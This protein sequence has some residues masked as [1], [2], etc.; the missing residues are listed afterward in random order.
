MSRSSNSLKLSDVTTIPIKV[1]YTSSYNCTTISN[2][3][4][5]IYDGENGS[6]SLTGSIPI[7]TIN[8]LSTRHLY[9]SN[10]LERSTPFSASNYDNYLYSLNNT[11]SYS[12]SSY[13]NYL[14]ST[15]AIGTFDADIRNFPT[16]SNNTIRVISIPRSVYGENISKRSFLLQGSDYYIVDDG[17]GNLVDISMSSFY[18]I[19]DYDTPEF[20][21]WYVNPELDLY[22]I[23]VGNIIYSQGIVIITNT[24]YQNILPFPPKA[25]NDTSTFYQQNP[26]KTIYILNNDIAGTGTLI[27]SSVLLSGGNSN[28]F[29]VNPIDGSV[30]LN[31]NTPGTYTTY[32]TVKTQ[33][34][35][36]CYLTS[37][38]AT[39]TVNVLPPICG[40]N[41]GAAVYVGP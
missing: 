15:A 34:P 36:G 26:Q 14:Q 22:G 4:I 11:G 7:E 31:I 17:N 20:T 41:G 32:Y 38:K 16:E 6:I 37:N 13:D 39:I 1:K 5:S 35:G 40:F 8:Y 12:T 28:L 2:V 29:T 27:P 33:I 10:Y 25:I 19:F 30:T 18:N 21:N 3:G 23:H 24:E 9:Y